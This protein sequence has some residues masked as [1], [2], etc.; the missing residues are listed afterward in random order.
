MKYSSIP[1][2][3]KEG[4]VSVPST[5]GQLLLAQMLKRELEEMEME[6]ISLSENGVLIAHLKGNYTSPTIGWI[7]HLD[8]ADIAISP[9]VHPILVEAYDGREIIQEEGRHITLHT[10]PELEKHIGKD[11]LFS[12]GRS[13]LGADNKA[14]IAIIMEALS[15]LI[16]NKDIPHGDIYVAFTPDEEV[17]LK[18]AKAMDLSL[19]PVDWGYTIDCQEK[20]EVVWE[21][22]NAGK[23]SIKIQGVSAH[24]MSSKGVLVN[25][26]LL[27]HSI[28]SLL[29]EKERP[30]NTEGKEG[31][32]WV[33]G[34]KGDS[35]KAELSLLIRDHD[36]RKYEE[37]KSIIIKAI[38]ETLERNPRGKIEYEIEDTYSNLIES[39]DRNNRIA[40]DNLRAALK[41]NGIEE[42]ILAMRGGTDGSFI[43]TKGIFVPNYFTGA[44]NFHS[45]SEFWPL[46]NGE[47][48]LFVTLNLMTGG[49]YNKPIDS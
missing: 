37:K 47:A 7:S 19:F 22:F 24:P 31:F 35:S 10:N 9:I 3:S 28:I 34:I 30:E 39:M 21:T 29:P 6:D 25:P 14:A 27:A 32:I 4:V 2:Q 26:I 43:S 45:T 23:A 12:D 49:R 48:S 13:V 40:V 1:S 42:K 33:K 44:S 46:E 16:K 5:P 41:A 18:G 38:E 17:G 15:I 8:T 11:I 20:G 36:K